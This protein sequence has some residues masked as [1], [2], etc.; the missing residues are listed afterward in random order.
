MTL[1]VLRSQ[2]PPATAAGVEPLRELA[3][4]HRLVTTMLGALPFPAARAWTPPADVTETDDA[5]LV[6]I[7]VPGVDRKHLTVEITGTVLRVH[8]EIVEK[9]KIGWLRHRTR[10]VGRFA[11]HTRLPG[12][13]DDEHVSAD[14]AGG[15]LTVRVPKTEA[16]RP[17]RIPVNAA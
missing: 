7:D 1:P 6:E 11:H 12:D 4:L 10:R 2:N 9:E 8:G 17:R 14:L 5:Y 3:S 15:V 13:I 16:A